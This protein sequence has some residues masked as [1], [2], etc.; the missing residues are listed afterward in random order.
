MKSVLISNTPMLFVGTGLCGKKETSS[1]YLLT[2][3]CLLW[4]AVELRL[5]RGREG[6]QSTGSLKA[7]HAERKEE[8]SDIKPPPQ[9]DEGDGLSL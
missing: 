1:G 5:S 3:E 7:I 9:I 6:N 8:L 2:I 4:Q